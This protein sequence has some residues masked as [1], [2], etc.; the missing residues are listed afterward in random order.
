[1]NLRRMPAPLSLLLA[2]FVP[3][4]TFAKPTPPPDHWVGTWATGVASLGN[5]APNAPAGSPP[6]GTTDVTL[7]QI[8]HTSL[9]TSGAAPLVRVE[10]TN[11]LGTEPLTIGA[12]HV[13]LAG[14]VPAGTTPTGDLSLISAN[15]LTFNGAASITIPAGG[16][17]ISDPAGLALPVGADLVISMF[18]P[19][20]KISV[21]TGH[22]GAFATNFY[23]PG[24]L[25]GQRSLTTTATAEVAASATATP[26]APAAANGLGTTKMTSWLF[27]KSVDVHA[28]GDTGAVVA[29]GD[30]ITDGAV[31]TNDANTRWP[32][33]LAR[34]LQADKK[35]RNLAVLNEGIGGNRV[36]H[37]G[38]GPSA[39]ARFDRE[40]LAL[41]G[42]RYLVILESINDIGQA[43]NPKDPKEMATADDLIAGLAQ[44]AERAHTHGIKV[45]GATLTPYMGAGYS[46]AKGE[47]VREAVNAWIRS[48]KVFDGVIDFEKATSTAATPPVFNPAFDHGDHL[49]PNDAGLKA[50][51]D[52]IDLKL[53]YPA[54]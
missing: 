47:E 35:T 51:A 3:A 25:V 9:P 5:G 38:Y 44:L 1:M 16:E 7:R 18:I 20:Q 52:A 45:F 31:S 12:V 11:A 14:A 37:D 17:A 29:F 53:F 27:L 40:V 24:N 19:A 13:A 23:A 46:S 6:F 8:V 21:I 33:D 54:K 10:F 50:M 22:G 28:T 42:V 48:N 39:V 36:L 4:A 41:P 32:D 49:H 34:R 2:L 15:A 43:Y 26:A 30:S